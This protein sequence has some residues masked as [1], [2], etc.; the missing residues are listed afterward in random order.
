VTSSER[1]VAFFQR[2]RHTLDVT[3][4]LLGNPTLQSELLAAV[5]RG[6]RVRL[7]SP[8]FVNGATAEIQRLQNASLALLAGGGVSVRVTLPPKSAKL[9]YMHAR[10]A[11]RDGKELYLGSIS[12][13]PESIEANRE[14][15]LLLGGKGQAA[16]VKAVR[17]RFEGDFADKSSPLPPPLGGA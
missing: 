16:A 9:P 11:V 15:G 14:V 1:L 8:L 12:L 3:S 4:E 5:E 6:V 13:S 17:R 2:A 10:T 7:I